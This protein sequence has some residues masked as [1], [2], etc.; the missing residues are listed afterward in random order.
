MISLHQN[1]SLRKLLSGLLLLAALCC[2]S[3]QDQA[4]D[5]FD[6]RGT[7]YA[8]ANTCV[9]CHPQ[10]QDH[11]SK[12]AHFHATSQVR[13]AALEELT[14]A[15]LGTLFDFEQGDQIALRFSQGASLMEHQS[16]NGKNQ[17]Y[18][19][20]VAF[21]YRHARTYGYWN[22][23]NLYELP[24]TYYLDF[25]K[26]GT[27][28]RFPSDVPHFDRRIIKD[29]F[30]CHASNASDRVVTTESF[31]KN[32]MTSGV[33]DKISSAT[34]VH[35]IDCERC[36]G[37]AKAHVNSGGKTRLAQFSKMTRQQRLDA[38]AL[39]HAGNDGIKMKSRFDFKPGDALKDFYS[40][41]PSVEGDVHGNQYGLLAQSKCFTKSQT[42]DCM[43][44]HNPHQDKPSLS[45]DYSKACMQ[46]HS[47]GIDHSAQTVRA[48]S[49][50]SRQTDCIS[51]HMP[52]QSSTA[53]QFRLQGESKDKHYQLR[54]HRIG[55]YPKS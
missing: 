39:C 44:C 38:C 22:N 17:D 12:T 52:A 18:S 26:W 51:C 20:D 9:S 41:S 31:R 48:L 27:S 2:F 21:G 47:G 42:M 49:L 23:G 43:S 19:L 35:G 55:I 5:Y 11:F 33:S 36:H 45:P 30:A 50:Q 54:T 34:L 25:E 29:C 32:A 13:G 6:P 28:P 7:D 4:S 1:R 24:L 37:P 3:C 15:H 53:I 40:P 46:C 10:I 8:G 16:K 14:S